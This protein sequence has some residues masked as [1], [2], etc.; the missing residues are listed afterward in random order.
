MIEIKQGDCVISIWEKAYL[1]DLT[2]TK[3]RKILEMAANEWQNNP[4]EI[5]AELLQTLEC[6]RMECEKDLKRTDVFY[7]SRERNHTISRLK[8][9]EK[10][11]SEVQRYV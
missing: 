3:F 6:E 9:I 2:I 5:R 1:T 7:T 4:E 8:K 11:K 10:M